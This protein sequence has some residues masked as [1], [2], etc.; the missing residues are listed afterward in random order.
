VNTWNTIKVET[1][2]R[3][4]RNTPVA[5]GQTNVTCPSRTLEQAIRSAADAI[6]DNVLKP[7]SADASEP[8]AQARAVLALL[9]RCYA[10]QIFRSATAADLA[11]RDPEFPWPWWEA[12]PD[13]GALRRFRAENRGALQRCLTAALRFLAEEKI[14]AGRLTRIDDRQLAEEAGRRIVMA[15]FEDSMEMGRE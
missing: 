9:A 8:L 13:A 2:F 1:V 10:Q 5:V 7:L 12:L 14:I 3:A 4:D 11:A 6:Q 15:A